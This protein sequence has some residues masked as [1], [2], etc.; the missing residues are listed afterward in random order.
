MKITS[1]SVVDEPEEDRELSIKR[2]FSRTCGL[3][4][5][6]RTPCAAVQA[7]QREAAGLL[8]RIGGDGTAKQETRV[9]EKTNV[10]K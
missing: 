5:G 2:Q 6:G 8:I 7:L 4:G 1:V 10:N 3:G 9:E